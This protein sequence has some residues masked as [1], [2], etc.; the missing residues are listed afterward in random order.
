MKYSVVIPVYNEEQNIKPL[1]DEL[2]PVM[3]SLHGDFEILFVNDGSTDG[4]AEQLEGLSP[5]TVIE[6]RGNFGQ[7]AAIDAGIKHTQGEII[8]TLDGDGQNPPG[9]IPAML[10]MLESEQ[11]DVVSGWRKHR[12]DPLRKRIVSR[13]ANTLRS[14]FFRDTIQDSGCTLKV[15]RRECFDNVDLFGEMHRF[16][17]AILSWSGFQIGEMVVEHRQRRFGRSKY[18]WK[19]MLKGFIDIIAIVFWRRYA[20]RPLHLFGAIGILFTFGGFVLGIIIAVR[21]LLY[22]VPMSDSSLPLLAVFLF[23]LGI[24]FFLSGILADIAIRTYYSKRRPYNIKGV[25]RR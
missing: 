22:S 18:T 9:E 14:L 24:Q 11:L 4:T 10:E 21:R 19:R 5:A 7:T 2:L 3:Q 13:A 12:N 1:H 16:I 15:Y 17:P 20:N 25:S 23:V 6:M 8:I